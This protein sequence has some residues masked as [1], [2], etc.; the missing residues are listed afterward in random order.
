[1]SNWNPPTEIGT[2]TVTIPLPGFPPKTAMSLAW[3]ALF[4]G[5]SVRGWGANGRSSHE[6]EDVSHVPAPPVVPLLYTVSGSQM[7]GKT[8]GV[9]VRVV[10]AISAESK[11][12]V[13]V[14]AGSKPTIESLLLANTVKGT[15]LT[16]AP[17]WRSMNTSSKISTSPG[18]VL[19]VL[20]ATSN[21]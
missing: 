2:D 10:G 20:P 19:A 8:P 6:L 21:R 3:V 7:C 13:C 12:T 18:D 17:G 9:T 4:H 11:I 5:V 14:V 16:G 1:M 15:P